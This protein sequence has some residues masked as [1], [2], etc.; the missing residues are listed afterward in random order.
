MRNPRSFKEKVNWRILRDRRPELAWTCDKLA[1]K[2]V[3]VERAPWVRVPETH[4]VG[5]DPSALAGEALPDRWVLKPNNASGLVAFGSGRLS[6]ATARRLADETATWLDQSKELELGE[7]AYG[8]AERLFLVEEFVDNGFPAAV[9]YR[10]HVVH[11][12]TE[13]WMVDRDRFRAQRRSFYGPSWAPLDLRLFHQQ[14]SPRPRP[15]P[16]AEM[17]RAAV[18]IASG[19]DF[20]RVDFYVEGP[21][22]WFGEVAAYPD[23][24]LKPFEPREFDLEFGAKWK[25]PDLEGERGA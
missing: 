7:W 12:K 13:L 11:G 21:T 2:R 17:D 22:V 9:D 15:S 25:L 24:G 14:D 5:E 10:A 1:C 3:A 23:S 18:A 4:W 16:L 6:T 20:L 19:V 8:R